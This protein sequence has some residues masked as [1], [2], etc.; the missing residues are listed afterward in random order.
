MASEKRDEFHITSAFEVPCSEFCGSKGATYTPGTRPRFPNRPTPSSPLLVTRSPF[1]L[2]A[3]APARRDTFD[4]GVDFGRIQQSV[5]ICAT[6]FSS[7]QVI[8]V[9]SKEKLVSLAG[10]PLLVDTGDE[11]LDR[12]LSGYVKVTTGFQEYCMYRVAA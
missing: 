8:V 4:D 1:F 12:M 10:R 2:P 11:E 3:L 5:S 6:S 9:A 7:E